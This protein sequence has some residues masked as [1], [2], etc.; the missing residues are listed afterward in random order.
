MCE[1]VADF[2]IKIVKHLFEVFSKTLDTLKVLDSLILEILQN[3]IEKYCNLNR[4]F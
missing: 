4:S 1:I 2:L 3:L